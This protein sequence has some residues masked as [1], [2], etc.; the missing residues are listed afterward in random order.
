MK[1][2]FQRSPPRIELTGI[3]ICNHK[4]RETLLKE[5]SLT[6]TWN[7]D[8]RNFMDVC[9]RSLDKHAPLNKKYAQGNHLPFMIRNCPRQ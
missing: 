2:T 8:I 1:T 5:L 4:F 6:N 7:N 3:T 9:V